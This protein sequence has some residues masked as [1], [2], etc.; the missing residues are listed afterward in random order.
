MEVG[1]RL[2]TV[3]EM[4]VALRINANTVAKVYR[5]L[6]QEGLLETRRGVGTF[7]ARA[8]RPPSKRERERRKSEIIADFLARLQAEG[9]ALAEIIEELQT[10]RMRR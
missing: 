7:I 2:P 6:E 8:E 4:A 9:I 10:I 1:D 5:E 3:R